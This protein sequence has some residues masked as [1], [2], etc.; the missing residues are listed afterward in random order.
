[1]N[2]NFDDGIIVAGYLRKYSKYKHA[3]RRRYVVVKSASPT[4]HQKLIY[5][6]KTFGDSRTTKI[7][8]NATE[9]IKMSNVYNVMEY[10]G[11]LNK[12]NDDLHFIVNE[13]FIF[14]C[15]SEQQRTAWIDKIISTSIAPSC[16]NNKL[17][18]HA[19]DQSQSQMLT[20][21][22]M[23]NE[24]KDGP[25]EDFYDYK[26]IESCEEFQYILTKIPFENGNCNVDKQQLESGVIKIAIQCDNYGSNKTEYIVL[27]IKYGKDIILEDGF[28]L[29]FDNLNDI[30]VM[31][32]IIEEVIDVIKF[33]LQGTCCIQIM[34]N[35]GIAID[36]KAFE[37]NKG[38]VIDDCINQG[39]YIFVDADH[40]FTRDFGLTMSRNGGNSDDDDIDH[41]INNKEDMI[42][43]GVCWK[44]IKCEKYIAMK[45]N[46]MF[47]IDNYNHVKKLNHFYNC[48]G[49][50]PVCKYGAQ[51]QTFI[52]MEAN[53]M[54][55]FE[56][57]CHFLIFRHP[58]RTDRQ[59]K[60]AN[61]VTKLVVLDDTSHVHD[62]VNNQYYTIGNLIF[63]VIKNGFKKDLCLSVDDEKK[64]IYSILKIVNEKMDSIVHKTHYQSALTRQQM[65]ALIL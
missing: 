2:G 63:E 15:V 56:D 65:L 53:E 51:C 40:R 38:K 28:Q 50:K 1:M 3:L 43:I 9:I 47:T 45:D 11:S 19:F 39:F 25:S 57:K 61:D 10:Y 42:G 37:S 5:T 55:T 8:K 52:R 29:T 22:T 41:D 35:K 26:L 6:F 59:I 13:K 7:E 36:L 48:I 21:A 49:N 18:S 62:I 20:A 4:Q 17:E 60:M 14:K 30:N 23:T 32:N 44:G 16:N 24:E 31:F 54:Q 27:S 33:P 58:P 34:N 12:N 46:N 64:D